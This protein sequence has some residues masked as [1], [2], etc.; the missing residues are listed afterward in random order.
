MK[1]C[2]VYESLFGNTEQ[3]A[4][5]VARG[6]GNVPV[7]EVTETT[8]ADLDKVDLIVLG[9]PTH[10]FSMTR[11]PTRRDAHRQ[12]ASGG[13]EQR[14]LRELIAEL[15]PVVSTPIATFDTRVA[16]AKRLPGSAAKAATRE[17][18]HH[19]H[20]AVVEQVSFYVEDTPGPLLDGELDRA[21]A[22]GER[23]VADHTKS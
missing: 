12:G 17:L 23:L 21:A 10:A 7:L 4:Q 19:H 2:V 16:K 22:W 13:D 5:A 20:A 15:P 8:A 3:L 14:G 1:A 6:M 9:G 11:P 18:R